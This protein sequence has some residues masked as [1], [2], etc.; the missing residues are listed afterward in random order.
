MTADERWWLD[1]FDGP[2]DKVDTALDVTRQAEHLE[3]VA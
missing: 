1:H 3:A 2:R